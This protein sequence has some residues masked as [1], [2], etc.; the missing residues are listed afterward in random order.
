MA[1]AKMLKRQLAEAVK[2]IADLKKSLGIY[3]C[4][5]SICR[6][7]DDFFGDIDVVSESLKNHGDK[8]ECFHML[9]WCLHCLRNEPQI[10]ILLHPTTDTSV[11][12]P[13]PGE[14][15][16]ETQLSQA[17]CMWFIGRLVRL[18]GRPE[19]TIL[20]QQCLEIIRQVL[21]V[22]RVKHLYVFK[23]LAAE[24][25]HALGE[26]VQ[27][28]DQLYSPDPPEFVTLSRFQV[29]LEKVKQSHVEPGKSVEAEGLTLQDMKI[30][31]ADPCHCELLQI[32]LTKIV[33][34]SLH[35]VCVV[36]PHHVQLLWGCLCCHLEFGDIQLK[37]CSL[38]LLSDILASTGLPTLVMDYFLGCV[39]GLLEF[40][41]TDC[42]DVPDSELQELEENSALMMNGLIAA[43]AKPFKINQVSV[44]QAE[45]QLKRLADMAVKLGL[46]GLRTDNMRQAM[47]HWICHLLGKF[48]A[49][50]RHSQ[51]FCYYRQQLMRA[52]FGVFGSTISYEF[53][54]NPLHQLIVIDL[55]GQL[56]KQGET[57]R[58]D[59]EQDR[60][61][62]HKRPGLSQKRKRKPSD[63]DEGNL[64][65]QSATFKQAM[66]KLRMSII[67]RKTDHMSCLKII[68]TVIEL[69]ARGIVHCQNTTGEDR[70]CV[71][72]TWL[73]K[74]LLRQFYDVWAEYLFQDKT[75]LSPAT[76]NTG[77]LIII[78]SIG[79]LLAL[80]DSVLSDIDIL[81]D[82]AWILSLP[83]L[84]NDLSWLDLRPVR[85]KEIAQLSNTLSDVIETA[86]L[87]ESLRVL[88]LLPKDVASKWRI[89]I[90]TQTFADSSADIRLASL[91]VM[92]EFLFNLGPNGNHLITNFLHPL[93][94]DKHQPIVETLATSLGII[95]CVVSRKALF[96][97]D[98][99]SA[100]C[101]PLYR[102]F[103]I[104]CTLCDELQ[105]KTDGCS[106]Q[107]ERS[108]SV[109]PALFSPF[110]QLLEIGDVTIKKA[111]IKSIRQMFSHIS[112]RS[113]NQTTVAMLNQCLGLVEDTDHQV[114]T[115]FSEVIQHL[116]GEEGEGEMKGGVD[117]IIMN[118]LQQVYFQARSDNNIRLQETVLYTIG[119]LGRVAEKD[120]LLVVLVSLLESLLSAIPLTAATAYHELHAIADHKK[121]STQNLLSKFRQGICKFL[122][123][124]MHDAATG[125]G[126]NTPEVIL[127]KVARALKYQDV[128]M[129]LQGSE[130]HIVPFL[131]SKAT[132]VASN[133]LKM[134]STL[135]NINTRRLLLVHN[136]KYIFSYLVRLCQAA[137]LE[138][139]LAF[140]QSEANMDLGKLIRLDFQRLHNELLLHL[141]SNYQQ[142]FNGL[143][144]LS[145]YDG[146]YQGPK[147]ITTP[148]QMADYLEP[149]LL[150]VLASFDSQL[151]NPNTPLEDKQLA[152]ESLIA[153]IQ[154]MGSKH[155]SSIRHK[156]MNTLRLGR[157]FVETSCRA[158][159]GFV[160]SL[161]LPLLGTM[162]SQ[163][164]ATLLPLL[165]ELPKQVADIFTYMIVENRSALHHH[166]HEVYFLP[167]VP[168]LSDANAVLKQYADGPSSQSDLRTQLAHSVQGIKH[169]NIDVRRRALSKLRKLLRE[170]KDTLNEYIMGSEVADPIISQLVTVLMAGCRESDSEAELL[171]AE[172]LGELG[173]IDP[174][175]LELMGNNPKEEMTKFKATV[176]DDNF[177]VGLINEALKAFLSATEPRVQ[178]CSA[179]ALQDL[180]QIY[181]ISEGK[182]SDK[183]P[184]KLWR[185]FPEHIQ[186][187]L[188]PLLTSKYKLASEAV[189][190]KCPKPIYQSAKGGNFKDWVSNWT[191][192]LIHLTSRLNPGKTARVFQACS[193]CIRHNIQVALYIL[194]HVVVQV[195]QDGRSDDIQEIYSE[196]LE[197]INQVKKPDTRHRSPSDF[198]HKSA[199]TVFSV[200]DYLAKWCRHR[201]QAKPAANSSTRQ[202]S[203]LNDAGY[204]AVNDFLERVPKDS[205]AEASVNCK[206]YTRA[207]MHFEQFVSHKDSNLQKHLDFV[208]RLYVAMDEP[209]GVLGVAAIRQTPSTLMQQILTHESLGQQQDAQACYEQAIQKEPDEVSHHQGLLASLM[210]LGQLNKALL[211]TTGVIAEKQSWKGQLNAYRIEASWKLGSWD[212][213][214]M[215][216]HGETHRRNWAVGV[217]RVLLA[218]K[219]KKEEEFCKQLEI[220]RREQM[221]PLSAAS[222]EM[223]SYHRGYENICRLHMLN[224]IEQVMRVLRD[225]P[226]HC[227]DS[228]DSAVKMAPEELIKQWQERIQMCQSSFRIQDPILTLRRTLLTL[229][230]S[231]HDLSTMVGKSWLWSTKV[232]RKSGYLQTAYSC[233]L[234][235]SAF[236][237]PELFLEK[238]KWLWEKG[239]NDEALTCLEKGISVNFS[240]MSQLKMDNSDEGKQKKKTYAQALLLYGRYS[241]D[242]SS[243]ESNA[244]MK[245][246]KDVID[247]YPRWEDGHF[248][249][250]KYY[251]KIMMALIDDKEKPEKQGE[252]II[253]V[254][255]FFGQSLQYGNQY[256]YQSMPRLL[257]LW[258]DYGTTVVDSEKK[259]RGKNSQK[260]QAQRTILS[261][262][263]KIIST[264]GRQ[265]QPYQFFTAFPQ[266]ISRI[267]HAHPDVFQQL[268]D[269]IANVLVLYPQQ[270]MWMLMAVSKSSYAMRVKRCQQIFSTS[271]ENNPNLHKFIMDATRLTERL[272]E[273][274]EKNYGQST[275]LSMSTHFKPL[276]RLLEDDNFSSILLP[277]QSA[278][279]VKL[280]NVL[281]VASNH[282]AF[283]DKQVYIKGFD[284]TIEILPSLQRPKKITLI[285]SDGKFYNMM[286]KPKDDLR[287]DCRL[288]EFNTIVNK[289]L[290]KDP[291]SRRRNLHIRTYT[292]VPLNEECGLLEWVNN[293]SGLRFILLKLYRE[294]G[295]YVNGKELKTMMPSIHAPLE[296][297]MQIFREKLLPRHPPVFNE[298]FLRTFPDPTSWYNAR[299]AYART[300][301]VMSMVG[302]ILGLGD[303]HGENILYDS[304][305]G[306]CVHVDF[307]CLFNKGETFEW[308]ERV[309]FRLTHNM[310]G[311]LGPMG[312]EGI[313]RQ[314]CEVTLR[315]MRNQMD[316]LM[317]I[318]KPFIYDPL[319]EWSKP[320]RGQRSNPTESGEISN[321]QAMNHVQN[322]EHR[323]KGIL[324]NKTKPRGLPLS[325]EG[326]VNYLIKE[327]TDEKNLSQMYIGWAAYL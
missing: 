228:G 68:Q 4:R 296:T 259:E 66:Q 275:T 204:N 146:H 42:D 87:C 298:W 237:L 125:S 198:R 32:N 3:E 110:L 12:A 115:R 194:P 104:K 312:V 117:N 249:L 29:P 37:I 126:D 21:L 85:A 2:I 39:A 148:E 248:Y 279:T 144:T 182:E 70:P 323:L 291:E 88:S 128:K 276:K 257:S 109:D 192:Y 261:R 238:A 230:Q 223:G 274:C 137:E 253:Y 99:F 13:K 112:I 314:A 251:D 196:I 159:N 73:S 203:Y 49:D 140:L 161:E 317:S 320:A 77:V 111:F 293:T 26:L 283:P 19:C 183:T 123:E 307:N 79:T 211:H 38:S 154:L 64:E 209:D 119:Q 46:T 35:E 33:H 53:I 94:G 28:N 179:F 131:V 93:T 186:E 280:P 166:F 206:A 277:L 305:T 173:A 309:P 218:A 227:V 152:M 133:L 54:V 304:T 169:E 75:E 163:I 143:R 199:Q 114:R 242:T 215:F 250:A 136:M 91:Q 255:K 247:I 9:M 71:L 285:G 193:A 24:I 153:I 121:M 103:S 281:G 239:N 295:I 48:P 67:N 20:H 288:M 25:V 321:E 229:C 264:L 132:P 151:V 207:L 118:R 40:L 220:I 124:A 289:F 233:L 61:D 52:L 205:L 254:V 23:Q 290:R 150:G 15:K 240:N 69:A 142:V 8:S 165:H 178:D 122:V 265:L 95:T 127:H 120:I 306:D 184:N 185:R 16:S 191:G 231:D 138:K 147:D 319:V 272:L 214:E 176:E 145:S 174:G 243:L 180:L 187:I 90:F 308:P 14:V 302:Y 294:K 17:F 213:L 108:K 139:A 27:I 171:Y 268:Q 287:K 189:W 84:P 105:G 135:L 78:Q 311:A 190:D 34:G 241:E 55:Q 256:I 113:H 202:A 82:F 316:P 234:Q 45:D 106:S 129:F 63:D 270:A 188:I 41:L 244:I 212:K 100:A 225:F 216:C 43:D 167:D 197:V 5:K 267:C 57:T 299:L 101:G 282:N 177:A 62:K 130:K 86:T 149:R 168:E 263:N 260:L 219:D 80:Q 6:F 96:K 107:K 303:R 315:V 273:L 170:D 313:F 262:I 155:I 141:S 1:D 301:A 81:T 72:Q 30:N 236:S 217:G 195:L 278:M 58:V 156:V 76:I 322:I 258:L 318:L 201:A 74:Q 327:A 224:E 324:K 89:H 18:L 164:V 36:D 292:V 47:S 51:L 44:G 116:L 326:H 10:Y 160:R 297:K 157:Q 284:D 200:L 65:K 235:A 300:S 266:L 286:C 221:G 226:V 232:A 252:F 83:W 56:P 269:L 222:M 246:Y 175:R 31:I 162:L 97:C 134:I 208:Q 172:C 59:V 22:V 7:L 92:P 50:L 102:K 310:V 158:W 98:D 271:K 210:E 245:Q 11:T 60:K 181:E 325:I